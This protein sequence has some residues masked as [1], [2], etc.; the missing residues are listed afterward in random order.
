MGMAITVITGTVI[1]AIMGMVITVIAITSMFITAAGNGPPTAQSISATVIDSR[2]R[3]EAR[4]GQ[5]LGRVSRYQDDH[6]HRLPGPGN[7]SRYKLI[8]LPDRRQAFACRSDMPLLMR[9]Y[10]P[11]KIVG[12]ADIDI[13]IAQDD[14]DGESLNQP[15]VAVA[16]STLVTKFGL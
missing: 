11:A 4:S 15:A 3:K 7:Q 13:A 6:R 10:P 8:G 9:S 1:T 2:R 16:K 5:G 14:G 12:R